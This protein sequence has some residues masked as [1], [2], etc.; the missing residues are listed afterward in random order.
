MDSSTVYL[1]SVL[2]HEI[3]TFVSCCFHLRI[4]SLT[5]LLVKNYFSSV[6]KTDAKELSRAVLGH[7]VKDYLVK[8]QKFFENPVQTCYIFVN[9]LIAAE[10]LKTVLDFSWP[11]VV[12]Y[13]HE[14]P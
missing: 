7:D 4:I 13:T 9:L 5:A 6:T 10:N 1:P 2:S 3:P 11:R 12:Q 8:P 14:I